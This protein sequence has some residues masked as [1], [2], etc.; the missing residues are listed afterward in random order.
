MKTK[1]KRNRLMVNFISE[2]LKKNQITTQYSFEEFSFKD[3]SNHRG[4]FTYFLL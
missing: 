2:H 1:H 3:Q 4:S